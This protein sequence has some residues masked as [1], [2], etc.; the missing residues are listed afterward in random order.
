MGGGGL[1][2]TYLSYDSRP[3]SIEVGVDSRSAELPLLVAVALLLVIYCTLVIGAVACR[4]FIFHIWVRH[5]PQVFTHANMRRCP[6][7]FSPLPSVLQAP[8]PAQNYLL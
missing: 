6:V 4:A 7:R 2:R 5:V 1:R 3:C 8:T